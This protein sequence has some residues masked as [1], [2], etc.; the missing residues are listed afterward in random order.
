[1]YTISHSKPNK[2]PRNININSTSTKQIT[3]RQVNGYMKVFL[4]YKLIIYIHTKMLCSGPRISECHGIMIR[5]LYATFRMY[6]LYFLSILQNV[7]FLILSLQNNIIPHS[8][9]SYVHYF[10][11]TYTFGHSFFTQTVLRIN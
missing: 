11:H 4:L 10:F 3:Q 1:M 2:N 8:R 6:N 7:T 9:Y 5:P